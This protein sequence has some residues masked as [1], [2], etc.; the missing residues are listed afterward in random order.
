MALRLLEEFLRWYPKRCIPDVEV[1]EL[2]AAT[3]PHADA[4]ADALIDPND[5][6]TDTLVDTR[7]D[8]LQVQ[9]PTRTRMLTRTSSLTLKGG[10]ACLAAQLRGRAW[11]G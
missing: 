4:L 9:V 10:R 6:F 11:K 3:P 2:T 7:A 8:V 1:D 5:A